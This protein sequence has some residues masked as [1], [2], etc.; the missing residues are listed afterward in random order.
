MDYRRYNILAEQ[1]TPISIHDQTAFM[2]WRS[3]LH[4]SVVQGHVVA[5]S[6]GSG[7]PGPHCP[8]CVAS[9]VGEALTNAFSGEALYLVEGS[10]LDWP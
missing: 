4:S 7:A 3:R 1:A 8:W 2:A 10:V 5:I 6:Q 9:P